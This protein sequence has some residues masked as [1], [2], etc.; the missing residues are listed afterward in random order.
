MHGRLWFCM[1]QMSIV[2]F[3]QGVCFTA[4][5]AWW[6]LSIQC[7]RWR[8]CP[9]STAKVSCV[10]PASTWTSIQGSIA[11]HV[12]AVKEIGPAGTLNSMQ[13]QLQ[14]LPVGFLLFYYLCVVTYPCILRVCT[15]VIKTCV[16]VS[17]PSENIRWQCSNIPMLLKAKSPSLGLPKKNF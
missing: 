14:G 1:M 8:P 5:V 6:A 7:T 10:G 11:C 15:D 12:S 16:K 9:G 17:C 4:K 13:T 3:V 2:G